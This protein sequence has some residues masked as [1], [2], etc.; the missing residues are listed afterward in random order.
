MSE[1]V[2]SVFAGE[3][4]AARVLRDLRVARPAL[5]GLASAATVSVG[6]AGSYDVGTTGRPGS[7][8]GFPG[9]FWEALFG[10]VFLVPVPGS[11]YGPGAGALFATVVQVGVDTR[12]RARARGALV[13]GTSGVAL[14]LTDADA[15]SVLSFLEPRGGNVVSARLT[16]A[17]HAELER[18]LGGPP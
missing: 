18:E 12:F 6:D 15:Q 5:D 13:P 7:G 4:S 11:S 9:M 14:L 3:E 10:L 16:P 2:L 1:L 8:L 17:Q